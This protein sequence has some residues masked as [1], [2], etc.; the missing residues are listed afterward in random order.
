MEKAKDMRRDVESCF[1]LAFEVYLNGEKLCLAGVE[2]HGVLSAIATS[3][4]GNGGAD[5]FLQVG[6][7][8]SATRD[9]FDWVSQRPLGVGDE[10]R[11]TIVEAA[12]VDDPADRRKA[13]SPT[14]IRSQQAYVRAWAKKFGW[15]IQEGSENN[16]QA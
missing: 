6:G 1:M 5:L 16:P 13:D 7:L 15:A 3:V 14:D 8:D 4:V 9:H 12:S 10:V 2:G 11:L